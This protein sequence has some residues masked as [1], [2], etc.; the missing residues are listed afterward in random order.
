[1]TLERRTLLAGAAAATLASPAIAQ[2]VSGEFSFAT[3]EWT[4]PNTARV[5]RRL[6]ESFSRKY[7]NVNVR[8]VAIPFAGF[9]DQMLTQLTAGTPPDLFRIDDPQIALYM[10]RSYLEKLD[11]ALRDASV[12]PAGFVA[13]GADATLDGHIYAVNY[14]TNPRALFYNKRLLEAGGV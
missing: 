5:L 7:P 4:L 14:Q 9:H 8:E 6:N 1:M 2:G 3:N 12:D 11:G 10:E 13:G